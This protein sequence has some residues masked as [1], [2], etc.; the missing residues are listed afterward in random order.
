[1][2]FKVN[3]CGLRLT[4]VNIYRSP[5]FPMNSLRMS[6]NELLESLKEEKNVLVMGDFNTEKNIVEEQTYNYKQVIQG[7]CNPIAMKKIMLIFF[8]QFKSWSVWRKFVPCICKEQWLFICWWNIVQVIHKKYTS[9]YCSS[10]KNSL[11]IMFYYI[12]MVVLEAT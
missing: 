8:R 5:H 12:V 3:C 1:M 10:D 11:K 7:K 6:M 9:P 2:V 4:I